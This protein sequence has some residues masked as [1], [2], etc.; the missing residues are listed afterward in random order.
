MAIKRKR[1]KRKAIKA[2]Q[3]V[4]IHGRVT[5]DEGDCHYMPCVFIGVVMSI[6]LGGYLFRDYC[7]YVR[8]DTKVHEGEPSKNFF[9]ALERFPADPHEYNERQQ[10]RRYEEKPRAY[11]YFNIPNTTLFMLSTISAFT[12]A[13]CHRQKRAALKKRQ[14]QIYWVWT[15][16]GGVIAMGWSAYLFFEKKQKALKEELAKNPVRRFYLAMGG[17]AVAAFVVGIASLFEKP[18]GHQDT[19]AEAR[20]RMCLRNEPR[21]SQSQNFNMYR[22]RSRR[23]SDKH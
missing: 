22:I 10:I 1:R 3:E 14:S 16:A 15:V 19:P 12:M 11:R 8:A 18:P 6:I 9:D 13:R 2:V 17:L 5:E 4:A 21:L 7:V 20:D 23:L